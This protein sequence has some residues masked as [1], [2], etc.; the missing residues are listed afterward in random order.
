MKIKT[1]LAIL[2]LLFLLPLVMPQ[3]EVYD[4]FETPKE[5]IDYLQNT[6]GITVSLA[7]VGAVSVHE[8]DSVT[9]IGGNFVYGGAQFSG[10]L[11]TIKDDELVSAESV[12]IRGYDHF[13][14]T[15]N[16]L[17]SIHGNNIV[18]E[19][20][21][22]EI[23]SGTS[24]SLSII[25]RAGSNVD[26]TQDA[27]Y[28]GTLVADGGKCNLH[29]WGYADEDGKKVS[30]FIQ[31]GGNVH[32]VDGRIDEGEDLQ[33]ID[34]VQD[35]L[36]GIDPELPVSFDEGT[37]ISDGELEGKSICVGEDC[38]SSKEKAKVKANNK[39]ITVKGKDVEHKEVV[40]KDGAEK[41]ETKRVITSENGAT[42]N[43][44]NGQWE[45][46][47]GTEVTEVK[48]LGA[49]TT[50]RVS[51]DTTYLPEHDRGMG[52][53]VGGSYV[54]I[55]E[56]GSVRANAEGDNN[57]KINSHQI[58]PHLLVDQV[59]DG[60]TVEFTEH[61]VG[62]KNGEMIKLSFDRAGVN[63]YPPGGLGNMNTNVVFDYTG[64]GGRARTFDMSTLGK[65]I[66]VKDLASGQESTV[67]HFD[68]WV[69]ENHYLT[70][71]GVALTKTEQ[72][73]YT[74]A[75]KQEMPWLWDL[76][77]KGEKDF[78]LLTKKNRPSQKLSSYTYPSYLKMLPPQIDKMEVLRAMVNMDHREF[79]ETLFNLETLSNDLA[80]LSENPL[81]NSKMVGMVSEGKLSSYELRIFHQ[82]VKLH[83][84]EELQ[85]NVH[86]NTYLEVLGK[87][88][89]NYHE[90]FSLGNILVEGVQLADAFYVGED[91]GNYK[92]GLM[93]NLI[94]G[95]NINEE[96][97]NL[98]DSIKGRAAEYIEG[99]TKLDELSSGISRLQEQPLETKLEIWEGNSE[100]FESMAEISYGK[101]RENDAAVAI[102]TGKNSGAWRSVLEIWGKATTDSK[103]SQE[104]RKFLREKYHDFCQEIGQ[105]I[106][107]LGHDK[108][109]EERNKLV[110]N[111]PTETKLEI[112]KQPPIFK[113][114]YAE[115]M[116]VGAE[117]GLFRSSAGL[118]VDSLVKEAGGRENF[119]KLME[120]RGYSLVG[121]NMGEARKVYRMLAATGQLGK[122]IPEDPWQRQLINT[123]VV[124]DLVNEAG[125]PSF[126]YN[127]AN[128]LLNGPNAKGFA[129]ELLYEYSL[130]ST[131][132]TEDGLDAIYAGT[133]IAYSEEYQESKKDFLQAIIRLNKDKFDPTHPVYLDALNNPRPEVLKVEERLKMAADPTVGW[134]TKGGDLVR[135]A[136]VVFTSNR[137]PSEYTWFTNFQNFGGANF[138]IVPGSVRT[139]SGGKLAAYVLEGKG[140]QY[141]PETGKSVEVIDRIEVVGSNLPDYLD[142]VGQVWNNQEYKIVAQR[143]HSGGEREVFEESLNGENKDR[144]ILL[145]GSC[146]G[147]IPTT[148]ILANV[149]P[150]SIGAGTTGTGKGN[151]NNGVL[152]D[153][154]GGLGKSA[155]YMD[156]WGDVQSKMGSS[157]D[158][159]LYIGFV[160]TLVPTLM[161]GEIKD[162]KRDQIRQLAQLEIEQAQQLRMQE[163]AEMRL[164]ETTAIEEISA[165]EEN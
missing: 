111:L 91:K 39:K 23:G 48:G 25:A 93:E 96:R 141:I 159:Q 80:A 120:Q 21:N 45:L 34:S 40:K 134:E 103:M 145:T 153:V 75:I 158:A 150:N 92:M 60:G 148:K 69:V 16:G 130:F 98:P 83:L 55:D 66:K 12:D 38:F 136:K 122:V 1:L 41:L 3:N 160:D 71:W 104:S 15:I 138:N 57:I 133:E 162:Y 79:R 36:E 89:P 124:T 52:D 33:A 28:T 6:Y 132:S 54:I 49:H 101:L 161:G 74:R 157:E 99:I 46:S 109:P 58:T 26:I 56:Y 62:Q 152:E 84:N 72:T 112:L 146:W 76:A 100:L 135:K 27:G 95:E 81:L 128:Q 32:L 87:I 20:G 86:L 47:A 107:K 105:T 14:A 90:A 29:L 126:T 125:G 59:A 61:Q 30:Q 149:H 151:I 22:L 137:D 18:I 97:L 119:V 121:E 37:D 94:S 143:G 115:T 5:Q 106:N 51:E 131:P 147:G 65:N 42:L 140:R 165:L 50:T 117:E 2:A 43:T 73:E 31:V 9:L 88:P 64:N 8:D 11:V 53:G 154:L 116:M 108:K 13:G 7:G 85:Q 70:S 44:E 110:K 164:E 35:V 155:N 68:Q 10:G 24:S 78:Y 127:S 139:D 163:E 156:I 19:E 17:A 63:V 77:N 118:I 4:S 123:Y 113:G 142:E 129:G 67:G 114:I 102:Y 144:K 82:P